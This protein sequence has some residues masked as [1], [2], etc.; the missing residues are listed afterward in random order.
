MDSHTVE[1]L[2][3]LTSSGIGRYLI[4]DRIMQTKNNYS[5]EY[6]DPQNMCTGEGVFNGEFGTVTDIDE[7]SMTVNTEFEDGKRVSYRHTDMNNIEL[8]YAIT[9]HKAQGCEF[10]DCIL[11]LGKMNKLLYR[12][13][14]L[15]TAITRGK[16]SITIIDTDNTLASFLKAPADNSRKTS[17]K[18]LFAI[19]DYK[20]NGNEDIK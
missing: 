18:D 12:R 13:N 5:L 16:K 9:V 14:I 19:I 11:V 2:S 3:G 7:G 8:A 17:L 10:D 15:Y 1:E 6:Y 20:Q 4:G